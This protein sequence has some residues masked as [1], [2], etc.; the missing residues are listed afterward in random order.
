MKTI[1]RRVLL[2]VA[3]LAMVLIMPVG[4][5]AVCWHPVLT[6]P[7]CPVDSTRV[8][9]GECECLQDVCLGNEYVC[10]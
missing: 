4:A 1:I 8:W 9:L 6:L 3:L 2:T 5:F 7:E 10:E